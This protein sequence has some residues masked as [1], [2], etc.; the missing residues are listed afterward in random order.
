MMKLLLNDHRALDDPLER[1]L[2][3]RNPASSFA[4]GRCWIL[5]SPLAFFFFYLTESFLLDPSLDHGPCPLGTFPCNNETVCLPQPLHCNGVVNCEDGADEKDCVND[6]GWPMLLSEMLSRNGRKTRNREKAA[7]CTLDQ[8]P[9]VCTCSGTAVRCQGQDL[10]AV[11]WISS[12]VTELDLKRNKISLL[13]DD[14]FIANKDL[15]YLFLQDNRIRTIAPTAFSGLSK[16]QR[17]YLSSNSI[18]DLEPG[19]FQDLQ[20]LK[21]LILDNN[22]MTHILPSVFVGLRSLVFLDLHTNSLQEM[23][24]RSASM[25]VEMPKLNWLDLEGNRIH[26][27]QRSDFQGCSEITV[28]ILNRNRIEWIQ[29]GAFSDLKKLVELDLSSNRLKELLPSSFSGL[30]ELQQL[31]LS[32][33]PLPRIRPDEFDHIPQ[34]LSLSLEG[35]EIPNI[36]NR[37][38]EKLAHLSH[39]YFKKFQYCRF[40]P[41]V[42]SCKPNTDGISSFENLLASIILRV[43]VWVVAF[44]SFFG[45]LFVIFTR[46]F[47]VTENSKHTMAIK[48]LCCADCLMGIY[49][50][51]LGAFDLKFSGEYNKHAQAW[52]ASLPCQLVGSLAMLS[53]EVSVLLLTYMTLEKYLCIV[54]PFS[55]YGANKRWTCFTLVL[56]WVLGFSLTLVPFSSKESFGIYYGRNGVCFPLQSDEN[57]SRGARGYSTGIFL[58]LNLVAFI[59]VVFAYASMFYSI[60]TTAART[61]EQSVFS[62]EVAVAKRFF[63][64]VFTNA[65][66]W[67]PIF[68]LKLLSLLDVEIPG[69]VTSWV[70]IFVLPINSTLNP[71]LYTLTTTSF[72]EKLKQFLQKK[73]THL[74]ETQGKS[75]ALL[76]MQSSTSL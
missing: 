6:L 49:L 58:G 31:N 13:L 53:S 2:S 76:S 68:I 75:F 65:L 51:F 17:L 21:W 70:V 41:H 69:T 37:M 14:Q 60:H 27:L 64:I 1:T 10:L 16:L 24:T 22:Q 19:V 12:D 29:E 61:A 36:Q 11:P 43:F 25:C 63:F 18:T 33:N 57:E 44:L 59:L 47:I 35:V 5:S 8:H 32:N 28:L 42:R 23:P 50:F 62:M 45:N 40:A 74:R 52:M 4:R 30:H 26:A 34:L 73:R 3:G 46:S 54:F 66:C 67:I 72:Q 15:E 56:I 7:N 71:I 39:I 20:S 48:S 9:E 38:F 55:H